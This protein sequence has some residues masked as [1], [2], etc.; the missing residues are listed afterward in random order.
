LAFGT[1]VA[2]RPWSR[3]GRRAALV[4][5]VPGMSYLLGRILLFG[6]D[7]LPDYDSPSV[8]EVA[9][10]YGVPVVVLLA[11]GGLPRRVRQRT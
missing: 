7:A 3:V 10:C 9:F 1:V 11:L 6:I 2:C 5:L 4:F 8:A